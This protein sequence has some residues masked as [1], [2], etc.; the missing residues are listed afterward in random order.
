MMTGMLDLA[1]LLQRLENLEAENARLRQLLAERDARIAELEQLVDPATKPAFK[2]KTPPKPPASPDRRR[3]PHRRHPGQQR[4]PPPLATVTVDHEV[5]LTACPY[6]AGTDLTPT[7]EFTDHLVEDLPEPCIA[8]HRYR[9]HHYQCQ[10]CQRTCQGRGDLELPGSHIGPRARLLTCYARTELGLSLGKTTALLEEWFG[11][12]ESRAGALGHLR[13]GANL[14]APVVQ[15]LWD[16]L[17]QAPV[18][19]AD[20][21]S[22]RINGKTAWAW[23]FAN[24]TLAL[25][26]IKERRNR[27]V[28]RE[29]LGDSLPG[30]LVSDFYVV[31]DALD[32][33]KQRCLVHLLR[34]LRGL[35][36]R[37]PA[38]AVATFVQPLLTWVQDAL[39]LPAQRATLAPAAYTAAVDA[40]EARFDQLLIGGP[41]PEQADCRRLW[42]RLVKH[43]G[44]LFTFLETPAVPADNNLAERDIRS[45]V[46]ARQDGGTHRSTESAGWFATLKSMTR[47]CKKQGLRFL[48]YGLN[49]VRAVFQGQAAPLPL[50]P[51]LRPG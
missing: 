4:K 11:L 15:R 36:D 3:H 25:F 41:L 51:E 37:L 50:Q 1:Q 29:A 23:C 9:R 22:W 39:A 12:R 28:L 30:V 24:N 31:Y 7:G 21:T 20:E 43:G 42:K 16:V 38:V 46:A 5:H 33:R 17:R 45:L 35:R 49:V 40:L 18:V 2:A 19:H 26:L 8:V 13:W 47:T 48:E 34:D 14:L 44:D 27:E 10:G 32:C 6:C